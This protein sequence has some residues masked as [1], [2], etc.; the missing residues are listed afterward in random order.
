VILIGFTPQKIDLQFMLGFMGSVI[1]SAG[2]ALGGSWAKAHLP[3]MGY[4]E[5]TIGTFL[6]GGLCTLPLI[7]VVPFAQFPP[8]A[9]AIGALVTVAATASSFAYILYFTL[10]DE[11]GAT[12]ALTTE[13]LVPVVAVI[14]GM[15]FL[16]EHVTV[17]Q[18]LGAGVILAGCLLVLELGVSGHPLDQD[19]T[20]H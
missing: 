8:S 13:F 16:H 10:V 2:F 9:K 4:Y 17:V 5:Q 15:L 14:L 20:A 3:H 1:G 18:M 6:F 11:I 19:V 12:K 7:A